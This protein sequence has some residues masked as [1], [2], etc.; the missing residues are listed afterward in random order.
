[1]EP[2]KFPEANKVYADKQPEYLPLP[3]F[4]NPIDMTGQVI[5]CWQLSWSERIKLLF[6]GKLW[7]TQLSFHQPL[8]PQRPQVEYPFE[9]KQ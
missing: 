8:Q 4:I 3:A 9:K 2:I 7:L 5:T 1:M 6:G